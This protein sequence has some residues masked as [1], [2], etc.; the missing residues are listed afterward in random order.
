M[1]GAGR[2]DS[3]LRRDTWDFLADR[4]VGD[5]P[6]PPLVARSLQFAELSSSKLSA[7]AVALGPGYFLRPVLY[8]VD[9]DG[10]SA[11]EERL[12]G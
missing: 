5:V 10:S 7:Y 11:F 9:S 12:P 6:G 2:G 8:F 4:C 1:P 3:R